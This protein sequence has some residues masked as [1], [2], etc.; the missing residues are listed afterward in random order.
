MKYLFLTFANICLVFIGFGQGNDP[1]EVVAE[2]DRSIEKAYRITERPKIKDTT[3]PSRTV[4]YPLLSLYYPTQTK[5]DKIQP[6]SIKTK[7]KLSKLYPAYIKLGIGSKVMPL[8]ELYYNSTR[9]RKYIYGIHAQHL[10]SF[11]PVKDYLNSNFDRTRT[12]LYGGIIERKYKLRGEVHYN[13]QGFH[14][15]GL[16]ATT[17]IKRDSIYQRYND[18]GTD[19]RFDSHQKDSAKLNYSIGLSYNNF[20]SKKPDSL[21]KWRAREN[22]VGLITDW[23]YKQGK[24][25]YQLGL[26]VLYNGYRYGIA[27]S[28]L[29]NNIDSGLVL[30]NTIVSLNP[31]IIT[32][33]EDH[34]FK[35][36]IGVDMV[37]DAHQKTHF[38]V[39][40]KAEVKYSLF[41]DVFIPYAGIRGGVNQGTFKRMTRENEFILPNIVL[42]NER[43]S[44]DLYGGFKGTLSNTIG[45]NLGFSMA[46]LKDKAFF[47][48]DT[49][50]SQ[51]N[52][53][54][55]IYDTVN[56]TIIEGS[57]FYQQ[58]EKIKIDG[59]TRFYS[60]SLFNNSYAWNLPQLEFIL[61]G[62]YNLFDKFIFNLDAKL[63]Q[64]RKTLVIDPND[65]ED[66]FVE[67]GQRIKKLGFIADFNLGIEYRYTKR[68]SAFLQ[69]NNLASQSYQRWYNYPVQAF[70]VLGGV[71]FRF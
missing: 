68:I 64:G 66:I 47:V 56:R 28:L 9:S 18:V 5:I 45:F 46:N 40:P 39:F 23:K 65:T 10:S 35:A 62:H 43:T 42:K 11:G 13:N 1:V 21:E 33:F 31:E 50:Y 53:F 51:G 44:Y 17:Q 27:D 36:K 4:E 3:I 71:T 7:E 52:K 6:A 37:L 49:T 67:N 30:N 22:F 38:Y 55:I 29:S 54:N 70:Q 32:Q 48:Q 69:L 26:D 60:Y 2:G 8:G 59:I 20:L 12:T 41:N 34:R 16:P 14:Y 57:I 24:E 19:L 61:R 63:E 15:Y 58:G 25:T